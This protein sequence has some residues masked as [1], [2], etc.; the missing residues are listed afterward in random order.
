MGASR[1]L[2]ISFEGHQRIYR[3]VGDEAY[4]YYDFIKRPNITCNDVSL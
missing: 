4:G 2:N 3:P 1:T